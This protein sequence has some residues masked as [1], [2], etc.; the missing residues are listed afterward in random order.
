M[1]N[2]LFSILLF[3][4]NFSLYVYAQNQ[5]SDSIKFDAN[6]SIA[7]LSDSEKNEDAIILLDHRTI[8][9]SYPVLGEFYLSKTMYKKIHINNDKGLEQFNK[10][11]IPREERSSM[12]NLMARTISKDGSVR[13][14]DKRN[15]KEI[16]NLKEYGNFT[17]F[18]LEGL[19]V[20]GEVEYY[21]TVK[22]QI[23]L[24][25]NEIFQT[26][27]KIRKA[28]FDISYY[29][30][31]TIDAKGY[32]GFPDPAFDP[33]DNRKMNATLENIPASIKSKYETY[34]ANLMKVEY[35]L[36][37]RRDFLGNPIF[38]YNWENM[39]NNQRD[40][41]YENLA[42]N[43]VIKDFVAS[44]KLG[45]DEKENIIAIE[46]YI[47][48]NIKIKN[49]FTEKEYS[50]AA[51]VLKNKYGNELGLTRLYASFFKY[52]KTN[53]ELVIT[54]NRYQDRFDK[55]FLN[56]SSFRHFLFYFPQYNKY[57]APFTIEYRFG[58]APYMFESNYG[59]ILNNK[60]PSGFH[61]IQ[62]SDT[63]INYE[64]KTI[65]VDFPEELDHVL[66][67]G[68]TN[69]HGHRAFR[70]RGELHFN[71][72]KENE[73]IIKN[74][75]SSEDPDAQILEAEF[76]NKEM[77]KSSTNE[78][79]IFKYKKT[80]TSML[81]KANNTVLFNIGKII[82]KQTELY[83]E[84]TRAVPISMPY[85]NRTTYKITFT[86]PTGYHIKNLDDLNIDNSLIS[87]D[88]K[89]AGFKSYYS[90]DKQNVTITI[91]EFY[92]QAT[93]DKQLY[94]N[95]RKVINSSADFNKLVL[96]FEK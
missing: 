40:N 71:S 94:S 62:T 43:W 80:S 56:N 81:E 72:D 35:V 70:Q 3:L 41:I 84:L 27:V 44:L 16:N 63:S 38:S 76:L 33:T 37:E 13:Y 39:H 93:Y 31:L 88:K 67:T 51:K 46:N 21:Y 18:V 74:I 25:G 7:T 42:S 65:H 6:P 96:I 30:P 1:K 48:N 83:Q 29:G 52:F 55:N 78:D 49:N 77:D 5:S 32:N 22:N 14:L 59:L 73:E 24:S 53:Y 2:K 58:I 87:N 85:T 61:L 8:K 95:F 92:A 75:A 12:A 20:G 66:V 34:Q 47:K 79:L 23:R 60:I 10:V 28:I 50:D 9:Y 57:I 11:Y 19:E 45:S 89:I 90:I 54:S 91:V 17:I 15:I 26:N 64:N 69:F 82:G 86:V 4:C 68:Q 36:I